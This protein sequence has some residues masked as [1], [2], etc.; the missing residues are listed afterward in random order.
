MRIRKDRSYYDHGTYNVACDRCGKQI[1]ARAALKEWTGLIVCGRCFDER[2]PQDFVRARVDHMAVPAARPV[3]EYQYN[4]TPPT[5]ITGNLTAAL[6]E[7]SETGWD[8][9]NVVG[10]TVSRGT[11]SSATE[12]AVLSGAN[13]AA[14]QGP[15]GWELIQFTTATLV[16]G[17]TYNL[18]R[19]LRGRYG[20]QENMGAPSGA[21]FL[22]LGQASP[23]LSMWI[24]TSLG[25]DC[26]V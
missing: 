20:T 1:K 5:N 17:L 21:K 3:P 15:N 26:N 19:L 14:I 2:H 6:L 10:V 24:E 25:I 22:Y 13:M 11:L 18:T 8:D 7:G 16:S 9:G 23:S 12:A 4:T